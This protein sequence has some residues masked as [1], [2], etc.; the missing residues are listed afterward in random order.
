M[1]VAWQLALAARV[2][3]Q[4]ASA[5]S[6]WNVSVRVVRVALVA[7]LRQQLI[8]RRMT[9]LQQLL[10]HNHSGPSMSS[11]SNLGGPLNLRLL[12]LTWK[13]TQ[14]LLRNNSNRSSTQ[15]CSNHSLR[16]KHNSRKLHSI[17]LEQDFFFINVLWLSRRN[18]WRVFIIRTRCWFKT[19]VV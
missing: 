15:S 14:Q 4:S 9:M 3:S 2:A 17:K 7:L 13:V 18:F 8:T 19:A 10:L 12:R 16:Y 5:A 6:S 11:C 1:N